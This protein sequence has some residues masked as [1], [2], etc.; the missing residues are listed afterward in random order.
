VF[1]NS[2]IV[3]LRR[4]NSNEHYMKHTFILVYFSLM[5][6]FATAQDA[7][8]KGI[9]KDEKGEPA[10]QANVIV[11]ASK[12]WATATNFDGEYS[13]SLP[14]GNYTVTYKYLGKEDFTF[15]VSLS[16]GQTV[17]KDVTLKEKVELINTVVVSASKYEKKMSEET[18]SMEVLKS[19]L[20]LAN[21]IVNV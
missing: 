4:Q 3:Y 16:E 15:R 18:V 9:V 12:G 20:M 14:P 11:D 1:D 19:D 13:L 21:N 10:L 5:C 17:T 6:L 2:K 7:T 8:L